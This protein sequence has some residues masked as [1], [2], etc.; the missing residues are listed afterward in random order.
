M[1][2]ELSELSF[3][4]WKIS[5]EQSFA[6]LVR[7]DPTPLEPP[8]FSHAVNGICVRWKIKDRNSYRAHLGYAGVF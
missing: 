2:H 8:A 6:P 7:M 4:F 5:R 3:E 1:N